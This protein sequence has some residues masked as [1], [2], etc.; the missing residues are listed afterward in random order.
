M[1]TLPCPLEAG[2]EVVQQQVLPR[3]SADGRPLGGFSA[4][5]AESPQGPLWLLSDAPEPFTVVLEAGGEAPR[6]LW[7]PLAPQPLQG[8]PRRPFD[9]EALVTTMGSAGQRWWM[10]SEGRL[11]LDQ[12]AELLQLEKSAPGAGFRLVGRTPLPDEWQP[13][14]GR[15]LRPNG[16]PEAL[17]PLPGER[18]LIAAEAP[19][20]QD[21]P[22]RLRLLLA[23]TRGAVRFQP[24]G[25]TLAYR[26]A[27]GA[28]DHWGL[29]ELLG[30]PGD[31]G[32]RL[33]ALWRGYAPPG[34]WWTHLELLPAPDP[35]A[36]A[37]APLQPLAV[38]DLQ[39]EG[40]AP[41]NWEAMAP[42]PPLPGDRGSLW[43]VS[44]DN[45]NPL[46]ANRVALIAPRRQPG[47]KEP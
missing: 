38:W 22:D 2:W 26:P 43:M 34:R 4:L 45:F 35:R 42:G 12:P 17:L 27:V 29:T 1:L 8:L 15:G 23:D 21:P 7:Q 11:N 30:L 47:C 18:L 10:A 39:D 28:E 9:G 41:D 25:A 13:R 20:Q 31:R 16:G 40:L 44:D 14:P 6:L 5:L 37:T 36:A 32:R 24:L 46:Q 33:L 3:T 19:L